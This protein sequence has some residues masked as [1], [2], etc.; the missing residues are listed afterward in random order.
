MCYKCETIIDRDKYING[1]LIEEY[2]NIYGTICP[3]CGSLI[4]SLIGHS[5]TDENKLKM[6]ILRNEM[7]KKMKKR[8]KKI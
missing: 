8:I 5:L 6:E 2:Q 1:Q 7:R 3:K 4:K